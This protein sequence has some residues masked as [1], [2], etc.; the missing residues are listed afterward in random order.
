M[1]KRWNRTQTSAGAEGRRV[2]A[3]QDGVWA[4]QDAAALARNYVETISEFSLIDQIARHARV[5]PVNQRNVLIASGTSV[6]T[7]AEGGVKV[8]KKLALAVD[9]ELARKVAAIVV[10]M[11]ELLRETGVELSSASCASPS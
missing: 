2:H 5:I 4:N 1:P 11:T 10:C 9:T 3:L 7:T 6:E 8:V